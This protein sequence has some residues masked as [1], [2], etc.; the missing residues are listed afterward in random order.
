MVGIKST[1]GARCWDYQHINKGKQNMK[2]LAEAGRTKARI[3]SSLTLTVSILLIAGIEL[4][5]VNVSMGQSLTLLHTFSITSTQNVTGTNVDGAAPQA[6]L[7]RSGDML[8]G[9]SV[10][11]A[12]GGNGNVFAL[13]ASG[14]FT[15]L[16]S[17]TP[18][19]SGTNSDGARP[20]APLILYSNSLFGTTL[21]GGSSGKGTV[22]K[23]RLDGTGFVAIHNFSGDDGY[24]PWSGLTLVSN[25]LF[26][27]TAGGG[28]FLQGAVFR[29][30]LDGSS[31]SVIHSFPT[32]TSFAIN[33]EGSNPYVGLILADGVLYGAAAYGGAAGNGSIFAIAP[34]GNGF[35]N[36]HNFS[37][38][39][40]AYTGTNEDGA[41]PFGSLVAVGKRLYGTAAF[42][43]IH[44]HGAVFALNMDG[45]GFVNLYSFNSADGAQPQAEL[46]LLGGALYGTT[47][48]GGTFLAGTV[49]SINPDGSGFTKIYDFPAPSGAALLSGL[50]AQGY[51][52]YGTT[53]AGGLWGNGTLFRIALQ[54]RLTISPS[55]PYVSLTWPTN[56][57]GFTLQSAT[58]FGSAIWT[59]NLS[60]PAVIE[61]QYTVTNTISGQ[62]QFY[63][64]SQ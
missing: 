8:Y 52:L 39:A 51:N 36:L 57:T 45:T 22:F 53:S 60:A 3:Q 26:G 35:T 2:I 46:S 30:N 27:T 28:A 7:I 24:S 34:D 19:S 37:P 42:G 1:I 56:F 32:N 14:N 55:G 61:S 31:F 4:V 5:T 59:T 9:T 21:S 6:S 41:H 11:G 48:G 18:T 44:G 40:E 64:L 62:P 38:T 50:S 47:S 63:R 13:S 10:G 20:F 33:N 12:L 29:L 23:V 58:N 15:N 54:P 49:F 43:G 16:Y 25:S 17:F